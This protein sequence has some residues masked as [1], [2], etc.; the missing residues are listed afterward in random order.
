M[1]TDL[2]VSTFKKVKSKRIDCAKSED[3]IGHSVH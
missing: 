1:N 3:L 2:F